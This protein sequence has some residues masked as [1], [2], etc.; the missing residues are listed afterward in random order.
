MTANDASKAGACVIDQDGK[1]S[2]L[3]KNGWSFPL[4]YTT[5][6]PQGVWADM[7]PTELDLSA[8]I[9]NKLIDLFGRNV[10]LASGLD[11]GKF[12]IAE[13]APDEFMAN[14]R[15][16]ATGFVVDIAL[17]TFA[18][19]MPEGYALAEQT[20][21]VLDTVNCY[22]TFGQKLY[23][24]RFGDIPGRL[25][26]MAKA[27]IVPKLVEKYGAIE[28]LKALAKETRI[29]P[30]VTQAFT[31]GAF[32]AITGDSLA[33]VTIHVAKPDERLK[34]LKGKWHYDGTG[35]MIQLVIGD[36]FKG[37]WREG[38]W[39]GQQNTWQYAVNFHLGIDAG[40]PTMLVDESNHPVVPKGTKFH[41]HKKSDTYI[42]VGDQGNFEFT[43]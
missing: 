2:L 13:G 8:L 28:L 15:F 33:K 20:G 11:V 41:I 23:N 24:A 12:R 25:A 32:G 22:L 34:W 40:Q 6:T 38:E 35:S 39:D 31:A 19:F 42:I 26:E 16:S 3:M 1:P 36:D 27:C 30:E 7:Y 29:L 43:R 10:A 14:G 18:V 4:M 37:T 9:R 17:A 5:D 21:L